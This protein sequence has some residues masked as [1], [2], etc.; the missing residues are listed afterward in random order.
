M[1][2]IFSKAD[3]ANFMLLTEYL[4]RHKYPYLY[5]AEPTKYNKYLRS[6]LAVWMT[7]SYINITYI[8]PSSWRDGNTL[9][10]V[11]LLIQTLM[12]IFQ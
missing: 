9:N 10:D 2:Q 12:K 4:A 7:E 8:V 5:L 1:T 3:F 6:T 11:S